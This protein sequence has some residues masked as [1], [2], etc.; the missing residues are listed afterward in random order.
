M[1]SVNRRLKK[2]PNIL[3]NKGNKFKVRG[4]SKVSISM[5]INRIANSLKSNLV[6]EDLM[7][8]MK[9]EDYEVEVVAFLKTRVNRLKVDGIISK[10]G[11]NYSHRI[12]SMGF[13]WRNM[14]LL[15]EFRERE[16][17]IFFISP[18]EKR[19]GGPVTYKYSLFMDFLA[20]NILRDL[21]FKGPMFTWHKGRNFERIDRVVGN[22][23]VGTKFFKSFGLPSPE[24]KVRS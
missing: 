19:G 21:G 15:E 7:D 22:M 8:S 6:V 1:R 10:L 4:L 11:F 20:N 5:A 12:E 23:D 18:D 17:L 2:P 3:K 24:T 9:V 13:F 14:A 16:I